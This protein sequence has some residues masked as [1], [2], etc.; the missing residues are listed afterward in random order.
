WTLVL[1]DARGHPTTWKEG[2]LTISM[3]MR[4]ARIGPNSLP[5]KAKKHA[6]PE[7]PAK[8]FSACPLCGSNRLVRTSEDVYCLPC[9]WDSLH[10]HADL[11]TDSGYP[12]SAP[13]EIGQRLAAFVKKKGGGADV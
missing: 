3:N 9:G 4:L 8:T 11:L 6:R 2:S 7:A 1:G 10:L 5:S 13:A 12:L